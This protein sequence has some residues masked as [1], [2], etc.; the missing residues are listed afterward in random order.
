MSDNQLSILDFIKRH[1]EN[2]P[3][4]DAVVDS[5]GSLSYFQLWNSAIAIS[6]Y[7]QS[8]SGVGEVVVVSTNVLS[9]ALSGILGAMH[10]GCIYS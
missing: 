3:E 6:S 1:A 5:S 10:A 4:Q 8:R 7:I 2:K 9:M